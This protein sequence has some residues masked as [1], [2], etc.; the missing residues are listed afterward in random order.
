MEC[1]YPTF[2]CTFLPR[3]VGFRVEAI[4]PQH[5]APQ[6]ALSSAPEGVRDFTLK[7]LQ[8]IA[9]ENP[10][11]GTKPKFDLPVSRLG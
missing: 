6:L 1:V 8:F 7:A 4:C 5:F 2:F 9:T 3:E 11:L 10:C